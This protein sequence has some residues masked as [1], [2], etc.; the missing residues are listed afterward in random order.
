[1]DRFL[2]EKQDQYHRFSNELENLSQ[3]G[4]RKTGAY[5]KALANKERCFLD[6]E[7]YIV[8]HDP[9][10]NA[11]SKQA[12]LLLDTG[13][14]DCQVLEAPMHPFGIFARSIT[15][16]LND[17]GE[18]H[19]RKQS[20]GWSFF[21]YTYPTA[22]DGSINYRG[23][24]RMEC[25][26]TTWTL[27]SKLPR[28]LSGFIAD[29]YIKLLVKRT[30]WNRRNATWTLNKLVARPFEGHPERFREYVRLRRE[31]QL[32]VKQTLTRAL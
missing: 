32:K 24:L 10:I 20:T 11:L 14:L 30:E 8:K 21:G 28:S 26:A 16:K 12:L 29:G 25:T 7:D 9:N 4:K 13:E 1:M 2:I 23:E 3:Q 18:I 15:G 6:V 5:K 19:C 31:I 22:F 27:F 17:T